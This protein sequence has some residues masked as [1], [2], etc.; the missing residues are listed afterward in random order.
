VLLLILTPI[1]A[2]V[3][4]LNG[5]CVAVGASVAVGLAQR[6]HYIKKLFPGLPVLREAAPLLVAG[7]LAALTTL[8]LAAHVPPT[9]VGLAERL[10][11]FLATYLAAALLLEWR[12]VGQAVR[13]LRHRTLE[14]E[15]A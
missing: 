14:A 11:C 4:G 6:R 7:S 12:L 3:A 10:A 2:A 5:F 9:K 8:V 13:L 15:P 1:G